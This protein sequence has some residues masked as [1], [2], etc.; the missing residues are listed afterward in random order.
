MAALTAAL[1]LVYGSFAALLVGRQAPHYEW[2]V[3]G[4]QLLLVP[5]WFAA[6]RRAVPAP[7]VLWVVLGAFLGLSLAASRSLSNGVVI[8]DESA[9]RFEARLL[10]TGRLK[11]T[12]PPGS[13]G[14]SSEASEPVTFNHHVISEKGW[15]GK[16]PIGWPLLLALPE[17]V[18]WGWVVT[19]ALGC[20]LLGLIGAIAREAFGE[21]AALPAVWMG[22]LSPFFLANSVGFMSHAWAGL[23]IAGAFLLMLQGIRT[24]RLWRFAGMFGL[25]VLSFQ[26]RPFSAFIASISLGTATLICLRRDRKLLKWLAGMSAAA[27]VTAVVS[28]LAYYRAFTG[29][30]LLS[31]YALARGLRVPVEMTASPAFILESLASRWRFS[32]QSM[33]VLGFPL[34]FVLAGIGLYRQRH[35]G[36]AWILAALFGATCLGYLVQPEGSGAV[37]GERYWF[38]A[39]FCILVLAAPV[40]AGLMSRTVVWALSAAQVLVLCGTIQVL[41]RRAE[42]TSAMRS[43]A[44]QYRNCDCVVFMKEEEPHFAPQHLNIND[45]D[46]QRARVF[47]LRDPGPAARS[48]WAARFGRT[49]WAVLEYDARLKRARLSSPESRL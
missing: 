16:Y 37:I 43:L 19:P 21:D 7:R 29:D 42:P 32:V 23:L 49:R 6:R 46:W 3:G 39:F 8:P 10:A 11:A 9:Y 25:L 31:P 2:L 15:Y 45:P 41:V 5:L 12:P 35:R 48:L 18:G 22:A 40:M 27:G 26:V 13:L 17:R 34:V 38:E 36:A 24:K 30:W 44:E 33:W 1:V 28:T 20:L 47:Y 4:L 14:E